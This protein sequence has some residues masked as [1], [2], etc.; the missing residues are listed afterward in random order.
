MVQKQ[1]PSKHIRVK[2]NTLGD[3]ILQFRFLKDN[4]ESSVDFGVKVSDIMKNRRIS[5]GFRV[6]LIQ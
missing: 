6:N 5:Y 3:I 1:L 4:S 2:L